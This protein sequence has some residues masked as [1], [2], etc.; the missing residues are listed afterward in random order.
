M[1]DNQDLP[2][3]NDDEE[4]GSDELLSGDNLRLPESANT[5]VRLHALRAWLTRRHH[6]ASVAVGEAALHLQ[7][8]MQEDVQETGGRRLHRRMHEAET[9]QRLQRAPQTLA[10]AQQCLGDYE[11]EQSILKDYIAHT[12]SKRA[13]VDYYLWL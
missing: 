8:I 4:I 12:S 6:E 11:E 1:D 5:L 7:Q 10:A 3:P 9:G 13:L 2:S